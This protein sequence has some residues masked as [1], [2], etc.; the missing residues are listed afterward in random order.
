MDTFADSLSLPGDEKDLRLP[1]CRIQK[2]L[3]ALESSD[4]LHYFEIK[5]KYGGGVGCLSYKVHF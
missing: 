1:P 3:S 5:V 2:N 4:D